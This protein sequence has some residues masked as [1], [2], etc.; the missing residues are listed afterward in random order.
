MLLRALIVLCGTFIFSITF[1]MNPQYKKNEIVKIP[2]G[3]LEQFKHQTVLYKHSSHNYQNVI[4]GK[5]VGPNHHQM[6]TGENNGI[7][8]KK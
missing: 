4:L 1:S 5:S 7:C 8:G 2:V 3:E 6:Y